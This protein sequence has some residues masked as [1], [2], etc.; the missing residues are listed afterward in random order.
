MQSGFKKGLQ[1]QLKLCRSLLRSSDFNAFRSFSR[2]A[3][4]S[5]SPPDV[6]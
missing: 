5:F 1:P 4:L 6:K 2:V 3:A